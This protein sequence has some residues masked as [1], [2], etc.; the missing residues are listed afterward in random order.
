MSILGDLVVTF[1]GN[2]KPLSSVLGQAKSL[3]G[4]WIGTVGSLLA[5]GSSV[6][7]AREDAAA[8]KKLA[9]VLAATGGAAG[10]TAAEI[11]QLAGD[12]QMATNFADE[13]TVSAAGTLAT[14]KSIK[15]D[16]FKEAL[17]TA[18]DLASVLDMDLNSA[19]R[20]VGKALQDPVSGLASL[21]KLGI[22]FTEDQKKQIKELVET[23]RLYQAQHLVLDEL[24]SSFGGAAKAMASPFTILKNTLGEVQ[25]EI[26]RALLVP[27]RAAANLV[28]PFLREWGSGLARVSV[29]ILAVVGVMKA[30][31]AVQKAVAV[32]QALIM[33]L[34]GPAGW[35]QLAIGAAVFAGS[36]SAINAQMKTMN[37]DM[38][39]A[40]SR[41]ATFAGA[42][43]EVG[44]AA[45]DAGEAFQF[46]FKASG[47]KDLVEEFKLNVKG[48]AEQLKDAKTAMLFG[49]VGHG[50]ELFE[51]IVKPGIIDKMTGIVTKI[52]DLKSEIAILSGTATEAGQALAEMAAKGA[53]KEMLEEFKALAA[54]KDALK[55]QKKLMDDMAQAA[56]RVYDE[57]R[58]P[59]EKFDAELGKLR[60]LFDEGLIDDETFERG[61]E[62][63]GAEARAALKKDKG[64]GSGELKAAGAAEQGSAA[65]LSTIFGAMRSNS[66]SLS[67]QQLDEAR[68]Q[69]RLLEEIARKHGITIEL[70]GQPL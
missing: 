58:N 28:L 44:A 9:A 5:A 3:L 13:L 1:G 41:S 4:G 64:S 15:G 8:Q 35:A 54:Q 52:K 50:A 12:L 14:F 26:G 27:M 10:L 32:G 55:E 60:D 51:A 36:L 67:R 70:E 65:A 16:V 19:A 39:A 40:T 11:S 66:D 38:D 63:L 20:Q 2:L 48:L 49:G 61:I 7:A 18:Q 21:H 47:T 17:T 6:D 53:P 31:T 43:E 62:K 29:A 25:E 30:I 56:K 37:A 45:K 22:A 59:F 23:N 57:T 68:E 69:T 33:S 42:V 46:A 34:G 24:K